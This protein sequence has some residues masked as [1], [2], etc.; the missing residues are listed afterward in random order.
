MA[1]PYYQASNNGDYNYAHSP[2]GSPVRTSSRS[3][4]PAVHRGSV[5][6]Q[7]NSPPPRPP[8]HSGSG[9]PS[10]SGSG[11]SGPGSGSDPECAR[12]LPQAASNRTGSFHSQAS[13]TR[14]DSP[15][16]HSQASVR[17]SQASLRSSQSS[18]RSSQSS[19]ARYSG[20]LPIGTM[21]GQSIQNPGF[22]ASS[23]D[24]IRRAEQESLLY[25]GI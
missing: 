11:G 16:R 9:R 17:S 24:D 14:G 22:D 12:T 19:M 25:S 4:S 7:T 3:Q 10:Q 2:P 1:Q 6:E 21:R 5:K 18:M 8:S 13:V 23:E 20:N 15:H